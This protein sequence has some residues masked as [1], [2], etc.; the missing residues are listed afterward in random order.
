MQKKTGLLLQKPRLIA[1][2]QDDKTLKQ[3]SINTQLREKA[4]TEP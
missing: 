3:S 1:K 4:D 2:D